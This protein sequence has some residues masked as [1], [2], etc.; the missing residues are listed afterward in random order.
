[1]ISLINAVCKIYKSGVTLCLND[2][3]GEKR[4]TIFSFIP[5]NC[6]MCQQSCLLKENKLF[7]INQNWSLASFQWILQT[8]VFQS[9][10]SAIVKVK[11]EKHTP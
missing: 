7:F 9:L 3:K 2:E 6:K 10:P 8:T 4:D 11:G 1:M 5:F